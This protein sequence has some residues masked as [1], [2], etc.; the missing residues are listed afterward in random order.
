MAWAHV[1]AVGFAGS[2]SPEWMAAILLGFGG[3]GFLGR[4]SLPIPSA[5]VSSRRR[6]AAMVGL[7]VVAVGVVVAAVQSGLFSI[8]TST[9]VV[10]SL[11][12]DYGYVALFGVFVIEGAMLL[13]FAPSE[14]VVPAAVLVLADTGIEYA[15]VVAIAVVGATV[16]QTG[17]FL[18]A[19]HGGREY[20]L[21]KR[22]FRISDDRLDQFDAW[23]DRWGTLSV[24]ASNTMLFTRGM[25]TV[26]A[27]LAGMDTRKFV[28]LSALGTLC[29][30]TILAGLTLGVLNVL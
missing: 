24:P 15:L 8:E 22:W 4:E 14:S 7:I 1:V 20:L 2:L 25:L 26:P 6:L 21:E 13:Y 23:F 10:R 27:G 5:L 30:E 17:L 29:F 28:V 11:F 19:K 12:A 3:V 18:L 16:G 9:V